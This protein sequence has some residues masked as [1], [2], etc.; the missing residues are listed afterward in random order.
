MT[1]GVKLVSQVEIKSEVTNKFK[2]GPID[3]RKLYGI[4][5]VPVLT[6]FKSNGSDKNEKSK[7]KKKKKKPQQ[8]M[9]FRQC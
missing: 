1:E 7:G 5:F 4:E 6:H 2:I 8:L 9:E 3:S